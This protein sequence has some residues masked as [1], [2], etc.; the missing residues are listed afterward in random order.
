M[1]YLVT[2]QFGFWL[3]RDCVWTR[4]LDTIVQVCS[5]ILFGRGLYRVEACL[6]GCLASIWCEFLLRGVSEYVL[7]FVTYL[8]LLL[9][10]SWVRRWGV[11]FWQRCMLM[12]CNF[13][14]NEIF[15]A[16]K[17][18]LSVGKCISIKGN[19]Q[20][21]FFL[22]MNFT[23]NIRYFTSSFHHAFMQQ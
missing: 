19:G 1:G 3:G 10:V 23:M 6:I 15:C 18:L 16:F 9:V 17:G 22:E 11:Q 8:F 7:V 14:N 2:V 12:A 21:L 20:P 4:N 13:I 5:E